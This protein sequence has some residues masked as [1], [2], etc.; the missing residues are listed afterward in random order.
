M[1]GGGESSTVTWLACQGLNPSRK[2]SFFPRSCQLLPI[3]PSWKEL[4]VHVR[5]LAG[6]ILH[7]Q[8]QVLWIHEW[9]S[10]IFG[11]IIYMQMIVLSFYVVLTW[12]LLLAF[13][14]VEWVGEIHLYLPF[15]LIKIFLLKVNEP[16]NIRYNSLLGCLAFCYPSP[17]T[18]T[19]PFHCWGS[20]YKMNYC[21]LFR[22][23][24]NRW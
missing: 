4:W 10:R 1:C 14:L 9:E 19:G 21:V 22:S 18:V 11:I 12:V 23:D 15:V 24:V 5:I 16:K 3:E 7:R 8:A 13:Y 2:P 6:L 20:Y 17:F